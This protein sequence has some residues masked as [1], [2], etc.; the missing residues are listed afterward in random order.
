MS[1]PTPHSPATADLYD[2]HLETLQVAHPIFRDYGGN[3]TFSGI[4]ETVRCHED[5][6]RVKELLATPGHGKVL[7]VDGG[8][9]TR[10]ALMGDLIAQSAV[11]NGWAGVIINGCIR[12][13]AAIAQMPLG[14]KALAT[15]PRKSER[16]GAGETSVV[17]AFAGV[18]FTPGYHLA[19]D[20]DGIVVSPNPLS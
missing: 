14:V 7:V 11:Q 4:I 1:D 19:A 3:K 12:D 5:N 17:V 8:A 16:R 18:I 9:S 13:A 2:Q 20:L 6:S 15:T 10:C